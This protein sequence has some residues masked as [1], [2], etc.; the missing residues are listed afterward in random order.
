MTTNKIVFVSTVFAFASLVAC[1]SYDIKPGSERIR[2]FETEPKGCIFLGEIPS[3]QENTVIGPQTGE[4][5]MDLPTR[6]D[7]RNKAFALNGNVIIFMNKNKKNTAADT[8][9]KPAEPTK[10]AAGAAPA[11][12]SEPEKEEKKI[13][14]VF[15]ATVFR[16]PASIVNQ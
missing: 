7:L 2:V 16:C 13:T 11:A 4:V 6:V 3:V 12:M 14:T 15:L 10:P 9:K 8:A 1:K 5:E